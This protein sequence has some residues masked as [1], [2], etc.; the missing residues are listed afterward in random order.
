MQI[1]DIWAYREKAHTEGHP[2]LPAEILQFGPPRSNKVRFLGGEY[3]GLDAWVP[4]MRLRVPWGRA[5]AW[6]RDERLLRA[7][8]ELSL[9]ALGTAGHEAARTALYA[10]PRP[11]G[12]PARPG[13]LRGRD[14][15]RRR[16]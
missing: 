6:L 3:P 4:K 1:G 2:V 13:P 11:D 5:E 9:D 12:Y 7:A 14:G 10:Y 16:A 15:A 8:R